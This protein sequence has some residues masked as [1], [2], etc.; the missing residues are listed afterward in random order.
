MKNLEFDNLNMIEL[1]YDEY[2]KMKNQLSLEQLNLTAISL[3]EAQ[4]IDGGSYESGY[5]AGE[6]VRKWVDNALEV[7]GIAALFA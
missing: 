3:E 5:K 4:T 2:I 7:I 1:T 6:F